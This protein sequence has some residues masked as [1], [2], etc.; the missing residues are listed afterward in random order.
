MIYPETQEH[1]DKGIFFQKGEAIR[2]TN[3]KK[4]LEDAITNLMNKRKIIDPQ[5]YLGETL[6][7]K[8]V[9][10]RETRRHHKLQQFEVIVTY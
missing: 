7:Q 5:R 9:S 10:N 1:L 6:I 3:M 8:D 4:S 2:Y